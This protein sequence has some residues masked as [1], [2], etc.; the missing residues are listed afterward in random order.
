[1]KT[2]SGPAFPSGFRSIFDDVTKK[3]SRP[4]VF[5][6]TDKGKEFLNQY[7]QDMLREKGIQFQEYRNPEVKCADVE[8]AHRTILDKLQKYFTYKNTFR[9]IDV[10]PKFVRA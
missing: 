4:P 6:R 7:F 1:M 10:L 5:V 8:R 2:K 3:N 9:N